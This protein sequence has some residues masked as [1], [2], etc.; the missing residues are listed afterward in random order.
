[1]QTIGSFLV[2][3]A[4]MGR[5]AGGAALNVLLRIFSAIDSVLNPLLSPLV[6]A[7]NPVFRV[8][9]DVIYA[10]L[11]P[12]PPWVGLTLISAVLGVVMLIAFKYTSNQ[13]AIAAAKD[14]I[15]A[16]L[17]ALK[18]F[19]DEMRVTFVSQWR[20]LKGV[21]R[22]QWH[23]FKPM[24]ILA[25]PMLLVIGQM[26]VRYQWRAL[27]PDEVARISVKL[28]DGTEGVGDVSLEAG[29][30]LKVEVDGVPGGGSVDWRVRGGA[31]GEHTLRFHIGDQ[32]IE[33]TLRVGDAFGPVSAERVTHNWFAQI[34]H[35]LEARL[36]AALPVATIEIAYPLREG[37]YT[38]AGWWIL[39]FFVVSMIAALIFAPLFKVRF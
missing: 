32:V 14:T 12:L 17:L 2:W 13:T 38:G 6:A 4:D 7:L 21:C 29:D 36:P 31:P 18:L 28:P 8:V 39:S 33:K 25:I 22:L 15:K 11:S 30:G 20:V 10:A 37:W 9:A 23:M 1:M 19:K 34:L 26:G 3:L 16:N 5:S 27:Q 24:L 35:P